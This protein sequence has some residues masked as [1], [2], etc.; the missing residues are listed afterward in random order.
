MHSFFWLIKLEPLLS[1]AVAIISMLL[2]AFLTF[3]IIRQTRKLNMQQMELQ[4]RQIKITLFPYKRELYAN[5]AKVFRLAGI[6]PMIVVVY[7]KDS[8]TCNQMKLNLEMIFANY[9]GDIQNVSNNLKEVDYL[10]PR[11]IADEVKMI[12]EKF[13]ELCID[14]ILI[15]DLAE[16]CSTEQM[17]HEILDSLSKMSLSCKIILAHEPSIINNISADISIGDLDGK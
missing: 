6:I 15:R 4:K 8:Y 9:L 14:L 17:S 2:T 5:L 3:L 10:L 1:L 7:K 16:K 12:S 11:N 13:N